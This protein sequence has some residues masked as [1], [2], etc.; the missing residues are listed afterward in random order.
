[1]IRRVL[2]LAVALACVSLPAAVHAQEAMDGRVDIPWNRYSTYAEIEEQLKEIAAAYPELVEL[3]SIGTSVEGRPLWVAIVNGK[4][5]HREKPAMWIDGN[6]HGNEIQAAEAVTYTLWYLTR[7]YGQNEDLTDLLDRVAFYLMPS[8]NPD[9]REA[10]FRGPSTPS[11]SRQNRRPTDNDLD[12]QIDED[13][14][15]DLDGDG[16]ITQM[17]ARDPAGQWVRDRFDPRIFRRVP[18]GERGEWTRLGQEGIDNDGDGRINEDGPFGDDMNRAYPGDWQPSYVQ[19]GAG[20]YPLRTPETRSIARFIL[21]HPN[22][23]ATQSY[24]NTGGML[25]RGPGAPYQ[26]SKYSRADRQV[27]D[28]LGRLG[29]RM[30][31]YYRYLIVEEDLYTVHGGFVTWAAESLGIVSFTNELWTVGKYFQRDGRRD[32]DDTWLWRDRLAFGQEFKDYE[33][34]E[35]PDFGTVLVGGPNKWS[36]RQ[37]PTFMLEEECH[38]NFAFTMMHA[39][40]MPEV[41]AET[42]SVTPMAS[43]LWAVTI[44]LRNHRLIPTRMPVAVRDAI[45]KPDLVTL[46]GVEVVASG[47]LSSR[48]DRTITEVSPRE[49][50]RVVLERGIGSRQARLMRFIVR[51]DRGDVLALRY[52]AEKAS[53]IEHRVAIEEMD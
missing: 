41:T 8:A 3:K 43:G 32:E 22:I 26:A 18:A 53:D 4:G 6:V 47:E 28:E 19:R 38:R 33:E 37:T 27:Y 30:I 34:V 44:E 46:S 51:A 31:P 15:D 35:H 10:W 23:A 24:H 12:G 52:T 36:S 20:D 21:E 14:P 29:S 5:D 49:P 40:A 2:T 1:M 9:G 42:V 25:L 48:F 13:G 7:A 16:S 45:G 17:W 50:G 39:D 11:T